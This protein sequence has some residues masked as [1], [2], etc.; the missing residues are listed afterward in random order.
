MR[1]GVVLRDVA[2]LTMRAALLAFELLSRYGGE[3]ALP[4]RRPT[5]AR[6]DRLLGETAAPPLTPGPILGFQRS[7]NVSSRQHLC[8]QVL[9]TGPC[10]KRPAPEAQH[11]GFKARRP[12]HVVRGNAATIGAA[13][14]RKRNGWDVSL[15]M[16]LVC[17]VTLQRLAASTVV[18]SLMSLVAISRS[19]V[20]V[21]HLACVFT[22]V[23]ICCHGR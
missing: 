13:D 16:R 18:S 7:T 1:S 2:A 8:R 17:L 19:A 10:S 3:A 21:D 6:A 12:A 11:E 5:R 14:R 4:Q 20:D 9:R 15:R 22:R 23:V